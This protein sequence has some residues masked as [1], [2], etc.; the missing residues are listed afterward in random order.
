MDRQTP[1][2]TDN[3]DA[4]MTAT[5]TATGNTVTVFVTGGAAYGAVA[6]SGTITGPAG[7]APMTA[8][9]GP[10]P[11]KANQ[12]QATVAGAGTYTID[13]TCD[14]ES[15]STTVTVTP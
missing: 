14:G 8:N 2:E 11:G 9:M 6:L 7:G 5:A 1:I 3:E 15:T 12:L 4:S 13:V 10:V